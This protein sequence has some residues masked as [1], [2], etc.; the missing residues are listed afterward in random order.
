MC[1]DYF[2]FFI[3]KMQYL[4]NIYYI[5]HLSEHAYFKNFDIYNNF[6]GFYDYV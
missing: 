4:R 6:K 5:M 2:A 1:S 3:E